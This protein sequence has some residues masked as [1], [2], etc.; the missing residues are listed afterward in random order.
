M[1]EINEFKKKCNNSV[2]VKLLL[3]DIESRNIHLGKE[4]G[5]QASIAYCAWKYKNLERLDNLLLKFNIIER[6]T[7][8]FKQRL[9]ENWLDKCA[10]RRRNVALNTTAALVELVVA[11]YRF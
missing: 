11:E 7:D 1:R 8:D 6:G 2:T 10:E 4:S 9:K 3:P 5:H